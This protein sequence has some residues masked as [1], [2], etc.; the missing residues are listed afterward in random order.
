MNTVNQ[1]NDSPLNSKHLTVN[2][3]SYR[4]SNK[5]S[6][7]NNQF[8]DD[9]CGDGDLAKLAKAI[10]NKMKLGPHKYI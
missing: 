1:L 3:T 6:R 4:K 7:N 9:V 8:V 10:N 5:K 2:I